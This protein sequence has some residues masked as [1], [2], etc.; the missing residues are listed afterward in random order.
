MFD[1]Y[2]SNF[3][4]F[5]QL[6]ANLGSRLVTW[7]A[8]KKESS[9]QLEFA[10]TNLLI[11]QASESLLKEREVHRDTAKA[12]PLLPVMSEVPNSHQQRTPRL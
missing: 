12:S 1:L 9:V 11:F 4:C 6:Q 2:T 5:P 8:Q 3:S 10:Q 7:K